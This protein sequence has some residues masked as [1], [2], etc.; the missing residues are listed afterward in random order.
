L[1]PVFLQKAF[2]VRRLRFLLG[3]VP[4]DDDDHALRRKHEHFDGQRAGSVET[5]LVIG[6]FHHFAEQFVDFRDFP[7]HVLLPDSPFHQIVERQENPDLVL[8]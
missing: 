6:L 8:V 4:R 5:E 3:T 7:P 2:L 1:F